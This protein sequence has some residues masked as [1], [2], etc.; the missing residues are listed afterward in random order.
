MAEYV[1]K[2]VGVYEEVCITV[3]MRSEFAEIGYTVPTHILQKMSLL[4]CSIYFSTTPYSLLK[5]FSHFQEF[6]ALY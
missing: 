2:L 4:N 1:N 5:P 6:I 3:Y